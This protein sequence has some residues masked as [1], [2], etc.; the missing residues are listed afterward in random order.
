M[1]YDAVDHLPGRRP[2]RVVSTT[3]VV[4]LQEADT[5]FCT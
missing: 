1:Q 5:G 2:Q 3:V 4:T